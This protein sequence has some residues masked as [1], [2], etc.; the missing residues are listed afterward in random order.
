MNRKETSTRVANQKW[1]PTY[2][3]PHVRWC[4]SPENETRKKTAPFFLLLDFFLY[5]YASIMTAASLV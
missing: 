2:A 1:K 5:I 4:E 3:E